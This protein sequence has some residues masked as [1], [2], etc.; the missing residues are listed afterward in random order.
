MTTARR[1][2]E[3]AEADLAEGQGEG[4]EER[5]AERRD[6]GTSGALG[7]TRVERQTRTSEGDIISY[8]EKAK[9]ERRSGDE[10]RNDESTM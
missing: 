10:T 8:G 2:R 1:P 9:D 3:G 7:F 5:G 4:G 6:A